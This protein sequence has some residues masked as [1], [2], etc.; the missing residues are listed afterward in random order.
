MT[1]YAFDVETDVTP[2]GPGRWLTTI[3]S[4]WNIDANPNGGYALSPLL[5]AMVATGTAHP[6]PISLTTH[7]LRPAVGDATGQI[8][9]ELVRSGRRTSTVRG[10]LVQDGKTRLTAMATLA[11]LAGGGSDTGD[12]DAVGGTTL[13]IP[14]PALASP[15]DCVGRPTLPQGVELAIASRVDVRIDPRY[16]TPAGHDAAVTAGWIRFADGRQP[17]TLALPLFTDAFPPSIFALAGR[18]GWVPTIELT[19][20]VRRRPAPGWIR[21]RFET[22]EATGGLLVEDGVLWDETDQVVARSRQLA[23]SSV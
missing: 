3:G 6:D 15:D 7:F 2:D 12:R 9:T 18:I 4:Q 14:P 20:H 21:A 23:M 13:T 11:D 22:R 10:Q 1:T 16:A 19:V 8:E 17:D 5:R